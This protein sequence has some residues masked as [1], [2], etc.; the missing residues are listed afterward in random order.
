VCLIFGRFFFCWETMAISAALPNP[1]LAT[2]GMSLSY[3]WIC[4]WSAN[5]LQ[6]C[7]LTFIGARQG[8]PSAFLFFFINFRLRAECSFVVSGPPR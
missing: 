1:V 4:A 2:A 5:Q 3:F 8:R 7:R 6:R